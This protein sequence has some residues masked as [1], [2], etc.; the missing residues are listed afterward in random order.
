MWFSKQ[1][2]IFY[3]KY[4]PYNVSNTTHKAWNTYSLGPL[5]EVRWLLLNAMILEWKKQWKSLTPDHTPG[6]LVHWVSS[7]SF[8]WRQLKLKDQSAWD[9]MAV[10]PL[11]FLSIKLNTSVAFPFVSAWC[12]TCSIKIKW[13][14]QEGCPVHAEA[15][16]WQ[17]QDEAWL[18]K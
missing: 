15:S 11:I 2:T 14:L 18:Q 3:C 1:W 16:L 10:V 12:Y 17:Q 7:T 9:G 8:P 6:I 4:V 13:M 5:R